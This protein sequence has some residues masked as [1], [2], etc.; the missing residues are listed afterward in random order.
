[1]HLTAGRSI[2]MPGTDGG[3]HHQISVGNFECDRQSRRITDFLRRSK[4]AAAIDQEPRRQ[5]PIKG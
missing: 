2:K 1:M 5:T 4:P 3:R